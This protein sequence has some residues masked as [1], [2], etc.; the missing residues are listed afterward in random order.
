MDGI[1]FRQY[2]YLFL[3]DRHEDVASSRRRS[4]SST[5][6]ACP[7]VSSRSAKRSESS[8]NST[9]KVCSRATY[10]ELDGYASPESVVQWYARGID[11][12]QGCEVTGIRVEDGRIA[13]VETTK[14]DIA[15]GTVVCCAGEWSQEIAAM[16]GFELPVE[17]EQRHMW[18]CP[19]TAGCPS[20]C[21]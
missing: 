8:R 3:L 15:C 11:V 18:F 5:G 21:R 17:G 20:G 10:C 19:R 13:G 6:S 16:A 4:R 7:R 2:G 1:D 12:R 14:G 9:R